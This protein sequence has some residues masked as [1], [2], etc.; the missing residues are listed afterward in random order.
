[1]DKGKPRRDGC[2]I[3]LTVLMI[4][5]GAIPLALFIVLSLLDVIF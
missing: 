3:A 5:F 4:L 1:M 2:F